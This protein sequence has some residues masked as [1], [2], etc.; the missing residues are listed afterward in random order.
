MVGE[1]AEKGEENAFYQDPLFFALSFFFLSPRWD[2]SPS[3]PTSTT[4][5]YPAVTS[6][7]HTLRS[8]C[9][10]FV[11]IAS[12]TKVAERPTVGWVVLRRIEKLGTHLPS[13]AQP[14]PRNVPFIHFCSCPPSARLPPIIRGLGEDGGWKAGGGG[15]GMNPNSTQL[16]PFSAKPD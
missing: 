16:H 15:P 4:K 1:V 6:C 2:P 8:L 12:A 5:N 7:I 13:S 3:P 9:L 14:P 11:F 10:V